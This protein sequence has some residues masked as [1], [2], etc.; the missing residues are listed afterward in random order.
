MANDNQR[1]IFVKN[2]RYYMRLNEKRQIDLAKDMGLTEGT[3]SAW[4]LGVR[5]PRPQFMERLANYFGI[6]V[7]DLTAD[8]ANGVGVRSV[9]IPVYASVGAGFPAFA[10]EEI[11]DEEE[12]PIA[13]AQTGEFFA[14][15]VRG[16]SMEPKISNGDVVIVRKQD[17]AE[18][19]DMVIAMIDHEEGLIKRLK[20]Y[21]T[22]IS[23]LSSNPS[24]EPLFFTNEQIEQLPVTIAGI[25]VELRAKI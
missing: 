3:I 6:S 25:V 22:G 23:L 7:S 15:R 8:R 4:C 12:I 20:T 5:Y 10:E 9:R 11:I 1:L 16:D 2:L 18:N 13:L 14:L 19:G 24:Y 17:T 21:Q